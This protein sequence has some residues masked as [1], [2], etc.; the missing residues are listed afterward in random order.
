MEVP[1][2]RADDSG[3]S[4]GDLDDVCG[5]GGGMVNARNTGASGGGGGIETL[6]VRRVSSFVKAALI[7]SYLFVASSR[8]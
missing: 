7:S 3:G 2:G 5:G 1:P 4:H 8:A 6:L